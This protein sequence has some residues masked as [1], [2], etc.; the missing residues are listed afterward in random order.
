MRFPVVSHVAFSLFQS[1][2]CNIL[3]EFHPHLVHD[4][5]YN[6]QSAKRW[7]GQGRS[8]THTQSGSRSRVRVRVD[9]RLI[10]CVYRSLQCILPPCSEGWGLRVFSK[11]IAFLEFDLLMNGPRQ[12]FAARVKHDWLS[13]QQTPPHSWEYQQ[14]THT[15]PTLC[16]SSLSISSPP[17]RKITQTYLRSLHATQIPAVSP[18]HVDRR[19][20]KDKL[21]CLRLGAF[22]SPPLGEYSAARPTEYSLQGVVGGSKSRRGGRGS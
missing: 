2:A 3:R 5:T 18:L 10:T 1:D 8:N 21:Q 9:P 6:M 13:A 17:Q 12:S 14:A 16:C 11:T 22:D 4:R 19:F 20:V 7:A 15:R